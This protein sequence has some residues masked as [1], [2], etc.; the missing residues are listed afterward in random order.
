MAVVVVDERG[1]L[2]IPSELGIR[3]TRAT[4]IP[5]GPFLVI[6]PLPSK[7]LEISSKW[8]HTKLSAKELKD[9]A[10]RRARK[11]AVQRARRRKQL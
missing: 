8:L 2:T 9:L 3:D 10:E 7:P 1:R 6:V 5:A 11:D 4:I